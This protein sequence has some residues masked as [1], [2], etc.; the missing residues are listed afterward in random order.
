MLK[1]TSLLFLMSLCFAGVKSEAIA[2]TSYV[3]MESLLPDYSLVHAIRV[4]KLSE[5]STDVT[6]TSIITD[7]DGEAEVRSA[8]EIAE[9]KLALERTDVYG[10]CNPASVDP[11]W[12]LQLLDRSGRVIHVLAWNRLSTCTLVDG[13]GLSLAPSL[14]SYMERAFAFLNLEELRR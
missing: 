1:L 5:L 11:R 7:F 13:K 8:D 6:I 3:S 2:S 14:S 9:L 4:F 10:A 12:L